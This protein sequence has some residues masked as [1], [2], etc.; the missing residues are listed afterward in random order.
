MLN[1]YQKSALA[2]Q[3]RHL[4]Q[5]L[6]RARLWLRQA[7]EDGRLTRYQLAPEAARPRLEALIE[8]MLSEIGVLAERFELE[9]RVE[10][11]GRLLNAEMSVA[12]SDLIDTRSPKLRRFGAVDPGL[13][14]ALDPHVDRLARWAGQLGQL[15]VSEPAPRE[16]GQSQAAP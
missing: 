7:P 14:D 1:P 8:Q 5:A 15:A 6:L 11:L 2:I 3:L 16:G 4:E 9:P 12:W 10:D 13:S